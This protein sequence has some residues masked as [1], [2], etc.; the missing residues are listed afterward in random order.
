M[1][2]YDMSHPETLQL[3]LPPAPQ[4]AGLQQGDNGDRGSD[5]H[6]IFIFPWPFVFV[7]EGG[8]AGRTSLEKVPGVVKLSSVLHGEQGV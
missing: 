2:W 1:S 3:L 6:I 5:N 8:T 7:S 4:T